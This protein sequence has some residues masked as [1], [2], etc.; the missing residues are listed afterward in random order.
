MDVAVDQPR[1][2]SAW[3]Q[4]N[5]LHL[6]WWLLLGLKSIKW[7]DGYDGGILYQ[8]CSIGKWWF[9]CA[10]DQKPGSNQR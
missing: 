7:S 8:Q 2:H 4:V 1:Q 9:V 5:L 10:I 6:R 3:S